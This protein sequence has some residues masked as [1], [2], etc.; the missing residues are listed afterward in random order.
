MQGRGQGFLFVFDELEGQ[1]VGC[2]FTQ[3]NMG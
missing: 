3:W 1:E 2:F